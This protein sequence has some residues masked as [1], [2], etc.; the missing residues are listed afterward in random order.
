MPCENMHPPPAISST[1]VAMP[2][3]PADNPPNSLQAARTALMSAGAP[4]RYLGNRDAAILD[5]LTWLRSGNADLLVTDEEAAEYEVK[6]Q[7]HAEDPENNEPP[8]TPTSTLFSFVVRIAQKSFFFTPCGGW[9]QPTRFA[10]QLA[11]VKLTALG[12]KPDP[13]T[14]AD[15]WDTSLQSWEKIVDNIRTE[16]CRTVKGAWDVSDAEPKRIRF[17]HTLFEV[18]SLSSLNLRISID[19]QSFGFRNCSGCRS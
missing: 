16:G 4:S 19:H 17:R 8:Q 7:L 5:G 13:P 11:A 9:S 10:S 15:D 18:R 1:T 2:S 14:F 6:R 12:E 3:A